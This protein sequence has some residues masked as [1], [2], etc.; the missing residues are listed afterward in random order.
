MYC[1]K[2]G[3]QQIT[4]E[5]R[6][7]S[8]CGL[9]ISGLA[10]WLAGGGGVLAGH[11]EE[12]PLPVV[13]P[14]RKGISRGAKLI[15]VSVVM[16]P[17]FFGLSILADNPIPLM[18]PFTIFLAGLCIMLYS[19][20]FGEETPSGKIQRA[21]P[22]KLSATPESNALPPA[23]NNWMNWAGGQRVRTAELA[24]PPSVTE[25]TTRLLDNE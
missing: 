5:M 16:I 18:L 8:R 15:F 17:I 1:P 10:E 11:E 13:S 3:L 14:R 9:P 22:H 25:H 21:Q 23:S 19:R 20:L 6:F 4:D 7:C 12:A 2:C 24:Q